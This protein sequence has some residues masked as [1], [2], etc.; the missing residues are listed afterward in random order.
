MVFFLSTAPGLCRLSERC[1]P[2]F[3]QPH[4]CSCLWAFLL[5]PPLPSP[6]LLFV[7]A[8]KTK[9]PK[10]LFR[11]V[12][13]LLVAFFKRSRRDWLP[14]AS[15]APCFKGFAPT[16]ITI[17]NPTQAVPGVNCWPEVFFH[18]FLALF[19]YI[20]LF[21]GLL[22]TCAHTKL[23]PASLP[24]RQP[25]VTISGTVYQDR[26]SRVILIRLG[27]EQPHWLLLLLISMLILLGRV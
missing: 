9:E 18:S 3:S 2:A 22:F 20:R 13:V 8:F 1:F 26:K 21:L 15:P 5:S 16:L 4:G 24:R 25:A 12:C 10:R 27:S 6:T 23:H 19:I 11:L 17:S 14:S 7:S